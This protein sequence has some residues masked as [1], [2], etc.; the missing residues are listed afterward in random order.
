MNIQQTVI[1]AGHSPS[2]CYEYKMATVLDHGLQYLYLIYPS[3]L[4]IGISR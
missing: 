1:M 2:C 4:Y 3:I